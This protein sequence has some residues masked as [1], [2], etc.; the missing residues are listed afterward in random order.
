ALWALFRAQ[1]DPVGVAL[2]RGLFTSVSAFCNAGFA[3]QSDSLV[4]YA[5][6]PAILNVVAALIILGGLSPAVIVALP[7]LVRGREISLQTRMV[8]ITTLGL[9]GF[10]FVLMLGLEWS[11]AFGSLS[12]ADR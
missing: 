10:G 3:L 5:T 9:L 1:G 2:W 11:H 4:P 8:L 12:W 7:N 6:S